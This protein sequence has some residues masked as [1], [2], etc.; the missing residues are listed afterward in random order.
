MP[1]CP[2][3]RE[4]IRGDRERVGARCPHCRLPLYERP[5][6]FQRRPEGAENECSVHPGNPAPGT[7]ARCGTFQCDLC[8]TRWRGRW[9][10]IACVNRALEAGEVRPD[11]QRAHFWEA[12]LSLGLGITGWLGIVLAVVLFAVAMADGQNLILAILGVFVFLG[13]GVP[14]LI[15]AGLGA[16]ALY[17]RGS[18]KILATFGLVLSG[19]HVGAIIGLFTFSAWNA[20]G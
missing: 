3:C 4:W 5:E 17:S 18:H 14:S 11:E 6:P 10:C 16:A 13:S 12:V 15:G 19:V 8:R 20:L 2:A 9:L 1:R 7:C